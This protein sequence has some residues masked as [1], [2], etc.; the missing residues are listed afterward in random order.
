MDEKKGAIVGGTSELGRATSNVLVGNAD[1]FAVV[2]QIAESG[3]DHPVLM[4]NLQRYKPGSGFPDNGPYHD[5]ITALRPFL[6]RVGGKI[7][8]RC[9]VLGQPVGDQKIDEVIAVWYPTHRHFLDLAES[10]FA[11]DFMPLRIAI[12]EYG[13]IHRCPAD[14]PPFSA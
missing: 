12:L 1:D 8:W 4:L 14:Q 2:R 3:R 6:D 7:L 5:Y 11:K 10:P 13:V 9:P